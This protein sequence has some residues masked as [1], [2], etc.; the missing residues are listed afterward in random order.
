MRCRGCGLRRDRDGMIRIGFGWVCDSVCVQQAREKVLSASKRRAARRPAGRAVTASV[1][2]RIHARD[3]VCRGCG[4][5][6]GLHIH[7][8]IHRSQGGK[9]HEGNLILLC[10]T[11]H[12]TAHSEHVRWQPLL[13][14]LIRLQYDEGLYLTVPQLERRLGQKGGGLQRPAEGQKGQDV[15]GFPGFVDPVEGD[16]QGDNE[17]HQGQNHEESAHDDWVHGHS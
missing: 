1:R 11:C 9:H 14:E 12:G 4:G 7:H 13:Q 5:T 17:R 2:E 3:R 6:T 10:V 16:D 8:V 15:V